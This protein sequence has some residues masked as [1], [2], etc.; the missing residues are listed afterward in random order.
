[1]C[2]RAGTR[3]APRGRRV[4]ESSPAERRVGGGIPHLA[5]ICCNVMVVLAELVGNGPGELLVTNDGGQTWTVHATPS[6]PS[7]VCT[8]DIAVAA[9]SATDWWLLCL[10][11]SS[12][13]SSTGA[14][15]HTLNGGS[16][17]T[18]VNAVTNLAA[19]HNTLPLGDPGAFGVGSGGK[20]WLTN[21]AGMDE[22]A[23]G[24]ITWEGARGIETEGAGAL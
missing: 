3:A 17:W 11:Q 6:G 21:Q 7:K 4:G 10:G 13:G 14:L 9:L 1:M 12:A 5:G 20:L 24:G 22:S 23:D 2:T 19:P 16:R 8:Q 18:T 15:F